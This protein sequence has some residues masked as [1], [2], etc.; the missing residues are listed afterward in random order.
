MENCAI[1]KVSKYAGI[2]EMAFAGQHKHTTDWNI[3]QNI[4]TFIKYHQHFLLILCFFLLH[5][6]ANDKSNNIV[7]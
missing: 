2:V 4:L 6:F 5:V 1:I 7:Q 3:K